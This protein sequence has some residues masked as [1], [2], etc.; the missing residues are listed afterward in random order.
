MANYSDLLGI[1]FKVHGRTK[2]DG[3]DCYGLAIEVLKRNGIILE[4]WFY[5]HIY[6]DKLVNE[7]VSSI[8]LKEIDTK[9]NNCIIL[10]NVK[11]RPL[12]CGVYIGN[13]KFIHATENCGVRIEPLHLWENRI[14][15][16][17]D[18]C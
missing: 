17:Y 4:D 14:K 13:G 18:V 5:N 1:K 11:N 16:Y 7:I 8:N 12:H 15:G 6:D 9:K 3:F 10:F 2:E